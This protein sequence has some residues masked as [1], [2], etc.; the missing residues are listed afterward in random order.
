MNADPVACMKC[1]AL[2]RPDDMRA[3][4]EWHR[5]LTELIVAAV[6]LKVMKGGSN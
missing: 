2:V 6:V 4:E 5:G 3:H 1:C